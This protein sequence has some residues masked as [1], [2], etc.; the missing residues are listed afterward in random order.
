MILEDNWQEQ[1]N[2]TSKMNQ[3]DMTCMCL[4]LLNLGSFLHRKVEESHFL[5]GNKNQ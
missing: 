5:L 3:E 2:Q 1:W 4:D